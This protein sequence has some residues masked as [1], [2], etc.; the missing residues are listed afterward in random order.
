MKYALLTFN[1]FPG[2]TGTLVV[3]ALSAAELIAD[4]VVNG[5]TVTVTGITVLEAAALAP[6][7]FSDPVF[8]QDWVNATWTQLNNFLAA[9]AGYENPNTELAQDY[10]YGAAAPNG[11]W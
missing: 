10:E 5:E 2:I 1:L 8:V 3:D 7:L 6:E 4:S 11:L 9:E